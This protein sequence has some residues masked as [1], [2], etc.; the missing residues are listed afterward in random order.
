MID[1]M[2][3]PKKLLDTL[4]TVQTSPGYSLTATDWPD[5]FVVRD[6]LMNVAFFLPPLPT[7]LAIKD[8][9]LL[10]AHLEENK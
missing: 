7:D 6:N 1:Y 3:Y 4:I 10:I 2:N 5:Q 8:L 9:G